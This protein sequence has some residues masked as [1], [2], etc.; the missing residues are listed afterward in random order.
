MNHE[1]R[2][3]A[4]IEEMQP[5]YDFSE[6]IQGRHAQ[7]Y[8][9][10]HLTTIYKE[11]GSVEVREYRPAQGAVTLDPDVAEMFPTAAAVNEALRFLL[12][13]ARKNEQI[14]TEQQTAAD[15]AAV[16]EPTA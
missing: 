10:G 2:H 6:A 4:E 12:R 14:A 15:P 16:T 9:E 8:A 7:R 1:N 11:D 5:E 13:V 3:L